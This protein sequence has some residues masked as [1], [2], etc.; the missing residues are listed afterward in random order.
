MD[1]CKEC[2]TLIAHTPKGFTHERSESCVPEFRLLFVLLDLF[3]LH[4]GEVFFTRTC[5]RV[6][7]RWGAWMGDLN[8]REEHSCV[9]VGDE[10]YPGGFTSLALHVIVVSCRLNVGGV[11]LASNMLEGIQ[12]L[13]VSLCK[14]ELR[15]R[16]IEVMI[17]IA[18]K[19]TIF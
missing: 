9:V 13:V 18:W 11:V 4:G 10:V 16:A 1:Q 3:V 12:Q 7:V 15:S 19:G 6:V 2:F 8:V 14:F 5:T 17:S